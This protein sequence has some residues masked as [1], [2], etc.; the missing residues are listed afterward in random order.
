MKRTRGV[1]PIL[2]ALIQWTLAIM[3]KVMFTTHKSNRDP[4]VTLYMCSQHQALHQDPA[5]AFIHPI[6]TV[7]RLVILPAVLKMMEKTALPSLPCVTTTERECLEQAIA[8]ILLTTAATSLAGLN[9]A[10][11][12][13]EIL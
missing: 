11:N 7:T 9:V 12:Q 13:V 6:M 2:L 4:L 10:V 5:F 3:D 1:M 8:H